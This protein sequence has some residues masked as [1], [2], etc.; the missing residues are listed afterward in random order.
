MT[1][2]GLLCVIFGWRYFILKLLCSC[3]F[4]VNV[5]RCKPRE[6]VSNRLWYPLTLHCSL[7]ETISNW[8]LANELDATIERRTVPLKMY[9][10]VESGWCDCLRRCSDEEEGLVHCSLSSLPI[11]MNC[12]PLNT[13]TSK[14]SADWVLCLKVTGLLGCVVWNRCSILSTLVSVQSIIMM[15][16]SIIRPSKS[17]MIPSLRSIDGA[18]CSTVS[19]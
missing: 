16:S 9:L 8:W 14:L 12:G 7:L 2:S 18:G 15:T 3:F 6:A 5:C 4:L 10:K 1:R 19:E 17:R 11:I 13:V